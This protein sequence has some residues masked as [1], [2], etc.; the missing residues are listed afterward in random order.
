M[1]EHQAPP[2]SDLTLPTLHPSDLEGPSRAARWIELLGYVRLGVRRA[3][4]PRGPSP[5]QGARTDFQRDFDRIVFSTAFRRLHDKTQVFPLPENDLVHSR[6]THSLEV[7]C[8]GRSLGTMVGQAITEECPELVERGL[9]AR[10]FGDIVAAACLAHDLGN[11]PFG[12]AGEDALSTWFREHPEHTR[13]LDAEERADLEGFEG[14]AQGFRILTRLQMPENPGLQLTMATLAAFTKYPR[15]AGPR[16][17]EGGVALKKHGVFQAEVE[18]LA[19]VFASLNIEEQKLE[20]P[21]APPVRAWQRHPLAFLMEAAD[22]LCYAILDIEDGFRL[23]HVPYREVEARLHAVVEK[24]ESYRP[25]TPRTLTEQKEAVAYLRAKAINFLASQV[26]DLFLAHERDLLRGTVRSAL[27]KA[28]PSSGALEAI[29]DYTRDTC[30]RARDVLEIELAGY[31][32]LSAL[33]DD[34]VPAVLAPRPSL[35]QERLRNLLPEPINEAASPYERILR[36]T[37]YLSG[38][39]DRYAIATYRKLRGISLSRS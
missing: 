28:I 22:D 12:H 2:G 3:G 23:G 9:D 5:A 10:A 18:L 29:T 13:A 25:R 36:V 14:N 26:R 4:A 11:P 37:D 7:S 31:E 32:V 35:K 21:R 38:M 20:V 8:V 24:D 27:S 17:A 33:L 19:E 16:P 39:T 15:T 6:L 34:L 30:Y 1:G